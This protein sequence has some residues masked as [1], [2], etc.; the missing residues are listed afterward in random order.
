MNN[1]FEYH[2]LLIW[3]NAKKVRNCLGV[4][5]VHKFVLQTIVLAQFKCSRYEIQCIIQN[6]LNSIRTDVF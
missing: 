6:S 1:R 4:V 5:K 2:L 3:G